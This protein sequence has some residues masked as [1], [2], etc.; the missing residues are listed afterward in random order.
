MAIGPLLGI[1]V[2]QNH[3]FQSLFLFAAGLSVAALLLAFMSKIP[4]HPNTAG[5]RSGIFEKSV[6]PVSATYFFLA[7]VYGGIT[8]FTPLFAES[9]KVNQAPSFWCTL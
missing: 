1:W 4:Y 3:S 2:I 5:R 6:L 9:I 8:A 7:I